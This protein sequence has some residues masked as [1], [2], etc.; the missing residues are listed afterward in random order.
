MILT[1][2]AT[3]M[4]TA[5]G[6]G[7][8]GYDSNVEDTTVSPTLSETTTIQ[9][10]KNYSYTMLPGQSIKKESSSTKV[11]METDTNSGVTT[12]TLISGSASI[13]TGTID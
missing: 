12:A 11:I 10:V 9:M 5:C 4:F 7:S 6:G 13:I 3:L 1:V 8:T 2:L